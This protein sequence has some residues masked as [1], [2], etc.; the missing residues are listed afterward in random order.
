MGMV[1]MW[2]TAFLAVFAFRRFAPG[3]NPDNWWTFRDLLAIGPVLLHSGAMNNLTRVT[4]KPI[5]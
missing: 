5:R 4:C 1:G 3:T 2:I